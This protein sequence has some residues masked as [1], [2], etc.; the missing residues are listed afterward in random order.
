MILILNHE[1]RKINAW[2]V[3]WFLIITIP[4][5]LN[6]LSDISM[7]LLKFAINYGI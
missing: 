7:S 6:L 2:M 5:Y 3:H 1:F 4:H